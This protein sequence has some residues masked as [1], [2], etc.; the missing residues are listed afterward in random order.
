MK[1]INIFRIRPA[2]RLRLMRAMNVAVISRSIDA[3]IAAHLA[4]LRLDELNKW[5]READWSKW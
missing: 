5:Q 1:E 3:K 2:T 4:Q